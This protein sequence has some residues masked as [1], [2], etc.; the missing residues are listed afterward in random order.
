MNLKPS[1][2]LDEPAPATVDIGYRTEALQVVPEASELNAFGPVGYAQT[3]LMYIIGR[4]IILM[5]GLLVCRLG[6]IHETL[7]D[8]NMRQN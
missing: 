3:H 5:L 2:L 8:I 6:D 7:K 1:P 4:G